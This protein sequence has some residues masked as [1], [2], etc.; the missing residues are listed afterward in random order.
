M[1][2]LRRAYRLRLRRCSKLDLD[3][4]GWILRR[5]RRNARERRQSQRRVDGG[6]ILAIA[7]GSGLG[8]LLGHRSP[9]TN[10]EL[11]FTSVS[12]HLR[13]EI[14]SKWGEVGEIRIANGD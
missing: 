7:M 8:E 10:H 1:H 14:N 3:F 9:L 2:V 11:E 5:L 4:E 6:C 13:L 12:D